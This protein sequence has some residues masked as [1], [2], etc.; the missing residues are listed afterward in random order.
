[1]LPQPKDFNIYQ[2]YLL[3]NS[4]SFLN[5][6]KTVTF[7][8]NRTPVECL[9]GTVS[10]DPMMRCLLDGTDRHLGLFVTNAHTKRYLQMEYN[11]NFKEARDIEEFLFMV[12]R[13][14]EARPVKK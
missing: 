3:L 5:T 13:S 10:L 8:Q 7:K 2:V 1:M 11:L 12:H 14:L 4:L 6:F 9:P